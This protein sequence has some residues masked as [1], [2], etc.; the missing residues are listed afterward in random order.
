MAQ[1]SRRGKQIT[2]REHLDVRH[3]GGNALAE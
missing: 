3:Y 2:F 1:M